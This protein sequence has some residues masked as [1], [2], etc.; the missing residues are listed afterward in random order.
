MEVLF[1][2]VL[3]AHGFVFTCPDLNQPDFRTLT[4]TRMLAQTAAAIE[5]A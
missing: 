2:R 3:E 4:T 1:G 5:A